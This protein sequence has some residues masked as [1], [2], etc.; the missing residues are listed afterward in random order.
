M[1]TRYLPNV[2][3]IHHQIKV[4]YSIQ[5]G[6][7]VRNILNSAYNDNVYIERKLTDGH[8]EKTFLGDV[9]VSK[10]VYCVYSLYDD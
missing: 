8:I 7:D 6:G 3:G 10:N 5:T 1:S 2:L 9:F 4:I